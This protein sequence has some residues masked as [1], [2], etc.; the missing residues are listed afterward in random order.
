M[1][2]STTIV[3]S[4]STGASVIYLSLD[5]MTDP[6]G[7][8][9]VIPYLVGLAAR[10]HRIRIVSLEK[11]DA[12]TRDAETVRAICAEAGIAWTPL[13]YRERP[14]IV[15]ALLNLTALKRTAKRLHAEN[16]A[17]FAHCRSDLPGLAGL[18]LKRHFALPMLYDMRAFWADERAEGG[19]W[20]QSSPVFRA[21]FS[22]FKRR[23]RDLLAEADEVVTLSENGR[24][25]IAEMEVRP[26]E[27]PVTVIPCCADFISFAPPAASERERARSELGLAV[28]VPLLVHVGSIGGNCL[29]NEMLDFFRVFRE[30]HSAAYFLFVAPAGEEKIR[31]EAERRGVGE[32]V[33]IRSARH[34]EVPRWIGAADVGIMFVRPSW[35]KRAASPTKLGEMLAVGLPAIAN[36]GVG[37]VAE[38]LKRLGAGITVETFDGAA[39]R[40]AI[41]AL[42][43]LNTG[44]AEIRQGARAWFDLNSGV[45]LYESVYRRLLEQ[46]TEPTAKRSA[47]A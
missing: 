25:A 44:G 32:A 28:Q 42:E 33:L 26:K 8:S 24:R 14:P 4:R 3:A 15:S 43:R 1:I 38:I 6:L 20:P 46:G 27:R 47:S 16:A 5:G 7:R 39:Y 40:A 34:E 13:P 19:D 36:S 18:A 23:Q 41:D 31:A 2:N 12:F 35:A 45:A 11:A 30:R 9:Q 21:I 29:L 17:D 37:D 22:Y 10:G